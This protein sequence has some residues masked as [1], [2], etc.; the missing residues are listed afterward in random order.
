M[1]I[2]MEVPCTVL[3]VDSTF[4]ILMSKLYRFSCPSY[5]GLM[6]VDLKL[7]SDATAFS[8]NFF[9]SRPSGPLEV[10]WLRLPYQLIQ[11]YNNAHIQDIIKHLLKGNIDVQF[12]NE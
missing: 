10:L 6:Y 8:L 5:A 9:L 4:Q 2:F 1:K 7:L 3:F 11:P 12:V